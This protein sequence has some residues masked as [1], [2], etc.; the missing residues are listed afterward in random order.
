MSTW[1]GYGEKSSLLSDFPP[2]KY[3]LLN[4][5]SASLMGVKHATLST[6]V[7]GIVLGAIALRSVPAV[8]SA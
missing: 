7:F 2:L 5:S 4:K 3:V 6:S 8:Y 1:L